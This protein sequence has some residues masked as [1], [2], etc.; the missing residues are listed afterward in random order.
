MCICAKVIDDRIVVLSVT[1]PFM[2][3]NTKRSGGKVLFAWKHDT[4]A[5]VN[6]TVDRWL[7]NPEARHKLIAAAARAGAASSPT[8]PT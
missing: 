3:S 1:Y 2:R 6:S 5:I 8:D 7:A 4:K